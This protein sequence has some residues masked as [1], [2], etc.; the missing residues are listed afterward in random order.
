VQFR[1][2]EEGSFLDLKGRTGMAGPSLLP[3]PVRPF[4]SVNTKLV[5][6]GKVTRCRDIGRGQILSRGAG[7]VGFVKGVYSL[8]KKINS[9]GSASDILDMTFFRYD[10]KCT[11]SVQ[12]REDDLIAFLKGKMCQPVHPSTDF[13]SMSLVESL[14]CNTADQKKLR[15]HSRLG[16]YPM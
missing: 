3:P 6:T 7:Q 11:N 16:R 12:F 2:N 1:H 13:T 9:N 4:P 5:G 10:T 8:Y 15:M 14:F